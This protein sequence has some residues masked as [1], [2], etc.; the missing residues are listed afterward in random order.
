MDEGNPRDVAAWL[1]AELRPTPGR[2]GDSLRA[3]GNFRETDLGGIMPG[4]HATVYVM[5]QPSLPLRGEVESMGWGVAT[6]VSATFGGKNR[7]MSKAPS[8]GCGSRHAS[9]CGSSMRHPTI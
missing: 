4:Q 8:T 1:V 3:I 6:D 2:L 5:A 9:R 7:R